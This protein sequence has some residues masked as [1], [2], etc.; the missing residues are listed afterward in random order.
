[1]N[2]IPKNVHFGLG[3]G[4]KYQALLTLLLNTLFKEQESIFIKGVIPKI[5]RSKFAATI[6]LN[7]N[8]NVNNFFN[9]VEKLFKFNNIN[10]LDAENNR[11]KLMI[12]GEHHHFE[13]INVFVNINEKNTIVF[14]QVK[15][16]DV[17]GSKYNNT[18]V[19]N[20][21]MSFLVNKNIQ[22]L[23]NI[24][25]FILTNKKVQNYFFIKTNKD[26][27]KLLQ[28][29]LE[30]LIKKDKKSSDIV[31]SK[32]ILQYIEKILNSYKKGTKIV[33]SQS[34]KDELINHCINKGLMKSVINKYKFY[35]KNT[36]QLQ[37]NLLKK[38]IENLIVVPYLDHR[39]LFHFLNYIKIDNFH[40]ELE[41]IEL[42]GMNAEEVEIS[43]YTD[44]L[45]NVGFSQD[46]V[47][48]IKFSK[49]TKVKMGK[50]YA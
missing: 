50:I 48:K 19:V 5:Y 37:I 13:D 9:S 25:M 11:F 21:I 30:K 40:K 38:I 44:I 39:I 31:R 15:G 47:N 18:P 1:M 8:T 28:V 29:I 3:F 12:E 33:W 20:A 17:K 4:F 43:K 35:F 46:E 6:P 24:T 16:K 22:N 10:I 42:L 14:Y 45:K 27:E 41:K 7:L 32:I 23:S 49:N 34:D 36:F 26:I 2:T